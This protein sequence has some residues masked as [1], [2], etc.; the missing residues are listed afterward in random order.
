MVNT[1][2]L[3]LWMLAGA[4]GALWFADRSSSRSAHV[5][6]AAILGSLRLLVALDPRAIR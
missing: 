2:L 5:P 1:V 3:L 6:V 4:T